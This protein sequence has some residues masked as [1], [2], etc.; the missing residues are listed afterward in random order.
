LLRTTWKFTSGTWLAVTFAQIAML[1][2]RF[3]F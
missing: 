2:D 1:G 3:K